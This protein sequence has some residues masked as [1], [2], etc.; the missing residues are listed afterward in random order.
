MPI[1]FARLASDR[2]PK[3]PLC[4][5]AMGTRQGVG[6]GV[7]S[8]T[9]NAECTP[10]SWSSM[11]RHDDEWWMNHRNTWGRLNMRFSKGTRSSSVL[12]PCRSCRDPRPILSASTRWS[13][14]SAKKVTFVFLIRESARLISTKIFR[15][16]LTTR[17]APQR[18]AEEATPPDV[19]Q[20]KL[21]AHYEC[22]AARKRINETCFQGGDEGHNDA[23]AQREQGN[24]E[25]L[26]AWWRSTSIMTD[27]D[28][29]LRMI[30]VA[31]LA[32]A[33]A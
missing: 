19:L 29:L 25:L 31:F 5:I 26:E 4:C 21:T 13:D 28:S 32:Q 1:P 7:I 2:T 3:A 18:H 27:K 30:E 20:S 14:D 9:H 23:I 10:K 33:N 22:I 15:K 11:V 6:G 12:V 8:G 24:L 17:A 16:E